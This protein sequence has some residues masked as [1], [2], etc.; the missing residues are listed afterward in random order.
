MITGANRGIGLEFVR[1]YAA[2]GWKVIA[3]CRNPIGVGD[4]AT[5]LNSVRSL[6]NYKSLK[7]HDI[8]LTESIKQH[9]LI[10]HNVKYEE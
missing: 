1:Q 7:Q 4:L 9:L 3:T 8:R 10:T 5:V 2:V 6:L